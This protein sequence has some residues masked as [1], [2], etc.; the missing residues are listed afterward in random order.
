[1]PT[2]P[3]AVVF[4]RRGN[5]AGRRRAMTRLFVFALVV[6]GLFTLWPGRIKHA[7]VFGA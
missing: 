6:A 3:L 1:M 5:V 7:V 4:A 2:V